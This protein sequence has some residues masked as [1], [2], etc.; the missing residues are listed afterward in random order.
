MLPD[1]LAAHTKCYTGFA[2]GETE[3]QELFSAPSTALHVL[4]GGLQ[5]MGCSVLSRVSSG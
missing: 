5:H 1:S 4:V 3:S 2:A